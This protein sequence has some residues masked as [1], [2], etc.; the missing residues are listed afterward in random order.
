MI[1]LGQKKQCFKYGLGMY[2]WNITYTCPLV[3][4][5]KKTRIIWINKD[6]MW[7][8]FDTRKIYGLN[9][10]EKK[11]KLWCFIWCSFFLKKKIVDHSYKENIWLKV[12]LFCLKWQVLCPWSRFC[13]KSQCFEENFYEERFQFCPTLIFPA[14]ML[15]SVTH[16]ILFSV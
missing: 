4:V 2:E 13:N 16:L 14:K 11:K 12:S 6:T 15:C 7:S 5:K 8:Y 3:T 10:S 9:S 1:W